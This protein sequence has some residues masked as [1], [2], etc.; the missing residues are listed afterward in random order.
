MSGGFGFGCVCGHV[1]V[2]PR[3]GLDLCHV[4]GSI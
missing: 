2:D 1:N 4:C 3:A